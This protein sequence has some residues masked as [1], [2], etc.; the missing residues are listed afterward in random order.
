VT[1]AVANDGTRFTSC[2]GVMVLRVFDE[3]AHEFDV[4]LQDRQRQALEVGET[5]VPHAKVIEGDL[6]T[7]LRQLVHE[8]FRNLSPRAANSTAWAS[9]QRSISLIGLRRGD[10]CI[11]K[12]DLADP[13]IHRLALLDGRLQPGEPVAALDPEQVRAPRPACRRRC[14]LAWISFLARERARLNC[15]RRAS[16]RG[17]I[18][19]RSSGIHTDSSSPFRNKLASVRASSLSVLARAPGMPAS[20]GL[21]RS[22]AAHDALLS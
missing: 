17:R 14:R 22:C 1:V 9:T 3:I 20:S 15:S 13:G 18:R 10:L 16:R 21:T 6:T 5:A 4:D 11:E 19:Q 7:K 12:L 2:R 8:R